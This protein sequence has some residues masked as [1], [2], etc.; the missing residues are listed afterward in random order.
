MR[1]QCSNDGALRA[2]RGLSW[3]ATLFSA[4][5][6]FQTQPLY[7][8]VRLDAGSS[9]LAAGAAGARPANDP[10]TTGLTD[11]GALVLADAATA[12]N[13]A[14]ASAADGGCTPGAIASCQNGIA[15]TCAVDGTGF[16]GVSCEH[17][18]N[19]AANGCSEC[20]PG[21]QTCVGKAIV[22]CGPNEKL[23]PMQTCAMGCAVGSDGSA[24]CTAC[25]PNAS[26]CKAD[27]L[28]LCSPDG[29]AETTTTCVDGCDPAL[30]LCVNA[31]L[32]PANLDRDACR[33]PGGND[34][35]VQDHTTIDTDSDCAMV[36]QQG[37]DLPPICVHK[38]KQIRVR[39]DAV[40]EVT[41]KR[42]LALIGT[43][44]VRIEG[45]IDLSAHAA[46]AGAGAAVSDAGVGQTAIG[47]AKP[48][49][50]MTFI[51]AAANAAGGGGGFGVPGA[52]GGDAPGDCGMMLP[53]AVAGQGG[54]MFGVPT[55]VPLQGGAD[56]GN[57]S[58]S[59][60]STRRGDPGAGGGA[61]ELIA[62][63][64]LSLG[65][66]AILAANGGGGGGGNP[67]TAENTSDTPGGGT[68]GGSGGAILIQARTLTVQ[69]GAL[70]VANGGGG[71]GGASRMS[72]P[73][74][75]KGSV[76][77]LAGEDGEDGQLG[78]QPAAGGKAAGDSMP[79]GQGGTRQAA[80]SGAS[81]MMPMQAAGGGG[82]AA[83]RIR[84]DTAAGIVGPGLATSPVASTG[85]ATFD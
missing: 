5:C 34:F 46:K 55:L 56:G 17:G 62:C 27:V 24:A 32:E 52:S 67:G 45:T 21:A 48:S 37:D 81:A 84:I 70:L 36:V 38:Y 85:R 20:T 59:E 41:G 42:A 10:G 68:G 8:A 39:A 7:Q 18:C 83:G 78:M 12:A 1:N 30:A 50:M 61:L 54:A 71:G 73:G 79:G 29:S 4:S 51:E 2:L 19:A 47:R 74:N 26:S 16:A 80:M 65:A 44:A 33:N 49:A 31:V 13:D 63:D 53:C 64:E 23:I 60:L 25:M 40:L 82:G 28:T 72:G 15:Q 57:N 11:A 69:A 77:L 9:G 35:D 6:S 66:T 58:A 14:T 3:L 75:G 43:G 76:M 22:G